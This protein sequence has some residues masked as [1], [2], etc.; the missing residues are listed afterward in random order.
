MDAEEDRIVQQSIEFH[1]M[2]DNMLLLSSS[3]DLKEVT[4]GGWWCRVLKPRILS[5][6]SIPN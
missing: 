5:P 4:L 6:S 2:L 1:H 3:V